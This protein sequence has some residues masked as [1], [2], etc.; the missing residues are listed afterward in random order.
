MLKH[1][2]GAANMEPLYVVYVALRKELPACRNR[3]CALLSL[4]AKDL[5][6]TGRLRR[7]PPQTLYAVVGG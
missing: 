7:E 3:G 5:G 4:S 1:T 2:S 6:T